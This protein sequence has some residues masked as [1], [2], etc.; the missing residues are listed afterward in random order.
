M[1]LIELNAPRLPMDKQSRFE[2]AVKMGFTIKAFHG[3]ITDFKEFKRSGTDLGIHFGT[4]DQAWDMILQKAPHNAFKD[5]GGEGQQR[6]AI[7]MPVLL[8][9]KKPLEMEDVGAWYNVESVLDELRYSHE[10]KSAMSNKHQAEIRQ[11]YERSIGI[12]PMSHADGMDRVRSII[13]ASGFDGIVYNNRFEGNRDRDKRSYIVFDPSQVRSLY[14]KFDPKQ[15]ASGN[16][17]E[18]K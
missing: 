12:S 9:I 15:A 1:K 18:D 13:Q 14:A 3:T 6:N 5:D 16:V 8:K 10:L 11:L 4:N 7:I 17:S 2:R